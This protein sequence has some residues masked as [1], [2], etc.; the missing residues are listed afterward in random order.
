M[1]LHDLTERQRAWLERQAALTTAW[2]GVPGVTISLD[3]MA[4]AVLTTAIDEAVAREERITGAASYR[5][6]ER[7]MQV[8]AAQ[9]AARR[10]IEQ[11]QE[12]RGRQ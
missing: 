2:A 3:D 8:E 10:M 12:Q 6:E 4:L 9:D 5:A 1:N 7:A 11:E